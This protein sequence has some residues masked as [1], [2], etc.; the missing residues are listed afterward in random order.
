MCDNITSFSRRLASNERGPDYFHCTF[1]TSRFES[2]LPLV[3]ELLLELFV[4]VRNADKIATVFV[5]LMLLLTDNIR[6]VG[7]VGRSGSRSLYANAVNFSV[8][9]LVLSELVGRQL[10][11]PRFGD[12]PVARKGVVF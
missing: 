8:V 12:D 11:A 1:H 3:M 6:E 2:Q 10:H 7:T 4:K 5:P 9:R